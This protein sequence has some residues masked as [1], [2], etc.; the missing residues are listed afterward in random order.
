MLKE[1]K[2]RA[3]S[4]G[5][6]ITY[7]CNVPGCYDVPLI[8]RELLTKSDVD[9]VVVLGSIVKETSLEEYIFSQL[10]G[11]LMDLSLESGKPVCLGVSG[12]GIYWDDAVCQAGA[13]AYAKM[14]VDAAFKMVERLEKLRSVKPTAYPLEVK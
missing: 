2:K 5:V 4:L 11:K 7:V 14:A 1:A 6:E 10:A 8:A 3:V 13:E 9:A 12:P